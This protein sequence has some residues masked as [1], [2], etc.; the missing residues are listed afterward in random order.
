MILQV[1]DELLFESPIDECE[2]HIEIIEDHS[3]VRFV[4]E[5]GELVG[6]EFERFRS[7]HDEN[8]KLR[9]EKIDDVVIPCDTVILAIGQDAAFPWIERD[10]GID[11]NEWDMPIVDRATFQTSIAALNAAIFVVP[12]LVALVIEGPILLACERFARHRVLGFGLLG[13]ALGG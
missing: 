5:D 13:M 1:H 7:T 6:M 3:P 9:Q 2:E 4:I 10:I 12:L 8:G 11:F